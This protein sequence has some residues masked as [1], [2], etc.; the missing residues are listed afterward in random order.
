M[1]LI[2]TAEKCRIE[3]NDLDRRA[4][5]LELTAKDLRKISMRLRLYSEHLQTADALNWPLGTTEK[6][7]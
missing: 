2:D 6:Q 3:A 5:D 1:H 4:S 7:A